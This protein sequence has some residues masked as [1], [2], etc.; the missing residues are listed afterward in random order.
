MKYEIFKEKLITELR[1]FYGKDATN[2][3]VRNVTDDVG[4]PFEGI[5]ITL[6]NDIR[7]SKNHAVNISAVYDKYVSRILDMYGCVEAI[8]RERERKT[9]TETDKLKEGE[10]DCQ[11]KEGGK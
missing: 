2:I 8:Y 6:Q 11:A 3:T 1:D 5:D 4:K 10:T 7:D 9:F